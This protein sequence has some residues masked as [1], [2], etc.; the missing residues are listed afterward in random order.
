MQTVVSRRTGKESIAR[1]RDVSL[2]GLVMLA[3]AAGPTV[4]AQDAPAAL[5]APRPGGRVI[6][7]LRPALAER[8]ETV[9]PLDALHLAGATAE[10]DVES[11]LVRHGIRSLSLV[12]PG[13][14]HAK[15]QGRPSEPDLS[16]T[17]VVETS[18]RTTAA[19]EQTLERLR[20]DPEVEVAARW[21]RWS[22]RAS[23]SPTPISPAAPGPT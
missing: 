13:R 16:T 18:A 9:L 6:V 10:P 14:L 4:I 2:A 7:K 3:L 5:D 17:Y 8:V 15:K 23:T 22:T 20:Q 11:F 12:H 1:R 21:W 19:L